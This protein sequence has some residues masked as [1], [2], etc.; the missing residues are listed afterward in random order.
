MSDAQD[1]PE[2]PEIPVE[3]VIEL[4]LEDGSGVVGANSYVS[5]EESDLYQ[6][7]R[8]REDWALLTDEQR[9]ACLIKATQYV[10][11]LYN[12]KGRRKFE[13]QDLAFPRVL[14]KDKD[15]FEVKGVPKKLKEAICEAAY[16]GSQNELFVQYNENGAV[17]RQK[18]DGAVE[19]E[20]FNQTETSI[21]NISNYTSLDYLLK[22]LYEPKKT[23]GEINATANWRY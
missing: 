19:I 10:D 15:G 23:R 5:L 12:W 22:G 2:K 21:D 6:A 1:I 18:V 4:I 7:K 17:K 8:Y 3:L 9:K 11:S 16:Y 14:I 13:D 20:Y